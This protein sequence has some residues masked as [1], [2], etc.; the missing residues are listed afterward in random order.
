M[1][2]E[3]TGSGEGE[4][5]EG[6]RVGSTPGRGGMTWPFQVIV[7]FP[8]GEKVGLETISHVFQP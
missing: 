6:I 4:S 8:V 7:P 2:C 3:Q 5:P 1:G